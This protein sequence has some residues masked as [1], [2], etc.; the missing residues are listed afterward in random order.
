MLPLVKSGQTQPAWYRDSNP[1]SWDY[2]LA[3]NQQRRMIKVDN[4]RPFYWCSLY[5][6]WPADYN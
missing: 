6:C 1:L 4:C 2:F 5:W 3:S